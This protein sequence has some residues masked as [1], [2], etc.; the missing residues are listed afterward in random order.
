MDDDVAGGDLGCAFGG[1]G[2]LRD[3]HALFQERELGWVGA[4]A[5]LLD[6]IEGDGKG[7]GHVAGEGDVAT[8]GALELAGE[9]VSVGEDEDVRCG[10]GVGRGRWSGGLLREEGRSEAQQGGSDGSSREVSWAH[11]IILGEVRLWVNL[12]ST[13]RDIGRL[14]GSETKFSAAGSGA[15]SL[16]EKDKEN[17]ELAEVAEVSQR[18]VRRRAVASRG[19]CG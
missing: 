3:L 16:P 13:L 5:E 6:L 15:N 11:R 17:A 4:G 2:L 14:A 12:Y 18:S 8:G 10:L 7:A 9:L 1:G 19:R